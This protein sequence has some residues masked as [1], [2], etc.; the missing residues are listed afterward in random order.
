MAL[1][2]RITGVHVKV[3][4]SKIS[5]AGRTY[6]VPHI[7]VLG[8]DKFRLNVTPGDI[9]VEAEYKLLPIIEN[10]SPDVLKVYK[11]GAQLKM[12]LTGSTLRFPEIHENI[13]EADILTIKFEE[14]D[15]YVLI[16]LPGEG[17]VSAK[18][19]VLTSDAE[20]SAN[21]ILAPFVT[22]LVSVVGPLR[23]K[24]ERLQEEG[25]TVIRITITRLN[26]SE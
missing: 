4:G 6:S 2:N 22:G 3:V 11:K 25:G 26:A 18:T 14:D 7:I 12:D 13:V 21:I 20:T 19:I 15:T 1:R 9:K 16:K 23:A 17:A 24:I 8:A 10:P 5:I